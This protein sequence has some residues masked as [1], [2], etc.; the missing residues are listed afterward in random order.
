MD[1]KEL[2]ESEEMELFVENN[3]ELITETGEA[4]GEFVEGLKQYVLD[5]QSLFIESDL[6]D[7]YKNI[8]LFTEV[9]TE[10]YMHEIVAAN[11]ERAVVTEPLNEEN[12]L[13]DYL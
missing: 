3:Q 9:A 7:M 12:A 1:L 4:V 8:R 5:N 11:A 2:Y 10:Q 6:A 13:N